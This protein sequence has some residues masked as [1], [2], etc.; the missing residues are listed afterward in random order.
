MSPNRIHAFLVTAFLISPAL[1][2]ASSAQS[3]VVPA[4][5]A[6]VQATKVLEVLKEGDTAKDVAFEPLK[7][8]EKVKLSELTKNGPVVLVVLRGFP[9]YQ[10]PLCAGQVRDLLR[11][12]AELEKLGATV[13]LIYPG[14]GPAAEL[15]KRANEFLAGRRLVGQELPKSFIMMVDPEYSFTN[16]YE[17]RWN[18]PAE[19]S[20]PSTFV[21]DTKRVVRFRQISV[22]HGDRAATKEVLAALIKLSEG[23]HGGATVEGDKAGR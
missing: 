12:S 17:L 1:V 4:P 8:E 21:L 18:A 15:K 6:Q 7:G 23:A 9:G 20:Y 3:P 2:C 13:M 16:L 14:P 19:T 11:N 5:A 22:T 10:C